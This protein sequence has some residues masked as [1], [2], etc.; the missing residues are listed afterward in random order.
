MPIPGLPSMPMPNMQPPGMPT[1]P[2]PPTGPCGMNMPQPMGNVNPG[3]MP[4][5]GGL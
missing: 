3:L 5:C 4:P 1:L 2:G